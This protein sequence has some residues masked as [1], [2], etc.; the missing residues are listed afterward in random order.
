MPDKVNLR[1]KLERWTATWT[2]GLIAAP[3]G[4][5]VKLAR[6]EGPFVWLRYRSNPRTSKPTHSRS[7]S[8]IS[9]SKA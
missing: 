2:P 3:N 4:Q 8:A 9:F 5:H 1:E 7:S 6:L